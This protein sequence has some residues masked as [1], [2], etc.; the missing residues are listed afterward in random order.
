MLPRFD[1]VQVGNVAE[2]LGA[3]DEAAMFLAGGQGLLSD[4]AR[5]L[6]RPARIV[7]ISG[8]EELASI[9][10][11][12]GAVVT[13]ATVRLCELT[14]SALPRGLELLSRAAANVGFE[15]IRTSATI[16]GN[17][18]HGM[19]TSEVAL[20]AMAAGADATVVRRDGST[21][22]LEG[23]ELAD[24]RTPADESPYLLTGLRWPVPPPEM[25][26]GVDVVELGEQGG[27]LPAL[28]VTTLVHARDGEV[29]RASAAVGLR[30]G[31]KF[32][33]AAADPGEVRDAAA[34][35]GTALP[36]EWV[37][38]QVAASVARASAQAGVVA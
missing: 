11:E 30:D 25:D 29:T 26:V 16:G 21:S 12:D 6:R 17:L 23:D 27:W 8:I 37:A 19:P 38:A 1:Y 33:L 24:L 2:A 34:R 13:G 28:A 7:D 36:A 5:G 32:V 31:R 10:E 4:M 9:A 3:A 20:A 22:L 35:A 18:C 15:P 14:G